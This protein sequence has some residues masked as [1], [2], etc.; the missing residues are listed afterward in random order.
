MFAIDSDNNMHYVFPIILSG[1]APIAV[2]SFA[3]GD[4]GAGS[5]ITI[6]TNDDLTSFKA[7]IIVKYTKTK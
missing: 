2:I 6:N 7:Y 1:L 3:E 4:G 5:D